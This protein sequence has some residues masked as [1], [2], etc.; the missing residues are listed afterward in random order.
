MSA[1]WQVLGW[2]LTALFVSTVA[3]IGA[4][5][6]LVRYVERSNAKVGEMLQELEQQVEPRLNALNA[7]DWAKAKALEESQDRLEADVDDVRRRF[8]DM[9]GS[10]PSESTIAA[11]HGLLKELDEVEAKNEAMR[12]QVAVTSAQIRANDAAFGVRREKVV[13]VRRLHN[14]TKRLVG[15]LKWLFASGDEVEAPSRGT[16]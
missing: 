7:E 5:A 16:Q 4:V 10:D 8:E 15:L 11:L 6:L 2:V 14:R 13:R 12:K 1:F 9:F 3:L